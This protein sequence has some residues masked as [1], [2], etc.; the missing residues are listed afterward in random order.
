MPI[1]DI[2]LAKKFFNENEEFTLINRQ[3]DQII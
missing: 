3:W 2:I 1:S